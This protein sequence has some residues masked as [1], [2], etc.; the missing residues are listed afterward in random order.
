M[1]ILADERIGGMKALDVLSLPGARELSGRARDRLERR[2]A[3]GHR[4]RHSSP[5]PPAL[6]ANAVVMR[7]CRNPLLY[8]LSYGAKMAI[9]DWL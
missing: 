2:R 7:R 9:P 3:E 8:P 4:G 1:R 5:P 6:A